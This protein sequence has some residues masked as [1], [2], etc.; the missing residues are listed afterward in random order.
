MGG[1]RK[2]NIVGFGLGRHDGAIGVNR[3]TIIT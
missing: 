3:P 1:G 2:A